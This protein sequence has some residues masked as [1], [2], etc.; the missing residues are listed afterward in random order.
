MGSFFISP[1]L[2]AFPT[3]IGGMIIQPI[4]NRK[5]NRLF[6]T[7]IFP[8]PPGLPIQTIPQILGGCNGIIGIIMEKMLK[9][10]GRI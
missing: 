6:K 9:I 7:C 10:G 2:W 8:L 4:D 1:I 5:S 3:T